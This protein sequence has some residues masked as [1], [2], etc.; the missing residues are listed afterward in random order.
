MGLFKV[1]TM[2]RLIRVL[3]MVRENYRCLQEIDLF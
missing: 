3:F 2:Q 1:L